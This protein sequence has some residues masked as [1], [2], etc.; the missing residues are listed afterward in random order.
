MTRVDWKGDMTFEA[1]PP[2]GNKFTMDA[3]TDFSTG[4]NG[5]TPLEA[6]ISSIAACSAVD[7]VLVLKK[8]RKTID[9]YHVEVETTRG[10]EGVYPRPITSVTVKHVLKGEGLDEESVRQAVAL[11]DEKYCTVISTLRAGADVSSV[12]ELN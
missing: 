2:S 4:E 5:P 11:S 8:K 6:L 10:P 9:S 3:V 7:V 12:Y 1:T